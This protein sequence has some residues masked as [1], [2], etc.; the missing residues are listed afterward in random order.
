MVKKLSF[1]RPDLRSICI[2]I[3]LDIPSIT[4][5]IKDPLFCLRV[6]PIHITGA[7]VL[8]MDPGLRSQVPDWLSVTSGES[9]T[10]RSSL[11]LHTPVSPFVETTGSHAAGSTP[12][13][14]PL[15]LS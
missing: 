13:L 6:S 11:S 3:M 8:I 10:G 4:I 7:S 2:G 1:K 14:L 15:Y 9:Q 12:P 5:K